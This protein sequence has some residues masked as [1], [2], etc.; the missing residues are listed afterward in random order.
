MNDQEAKFIGIDI[1]EKMEW[2][3]I[4]PSMDGQRRDFALDNARFIALDDTILSQ[5]YDRI[6]RPRALATHHWP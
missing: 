2:P 4:T 3:S 1:A 6:A 5:Y